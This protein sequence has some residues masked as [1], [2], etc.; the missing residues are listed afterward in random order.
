M[1]LKTFLLSFKPHLSQTSIAEK[2]RSGLAG[3]IAILLLTLAL[4]HLPQTLFPL[5]IVASMAASATLLYATPHSPLAQPW[6]LVGGH[7]VS[8]LAGLA[9]GALIPEPTL[10]AGAAVGSAIL[11]MELLSCLH[12]PSAATSLMMVLGSSQLHEMNW[13]W[14]L[15]IV[16][17]NV[18][19]SLVL[20]LIINNALPGR[21]YPM[22]ALHNPVSPKPA[23]F[24]TLEQSDIAWAL[25]QMNSEIDVSEEDL[26][27]IYKLSLQQAQTRIDRQFPR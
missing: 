1:D 19:I 27:E 8:A 14:A 11:L 26:A 5:L 15:A 13:Q 24:I 20:A 9:C 17:I 18:G 22:H 7:L 10:A 16:T 25:Q 2:L 3:G 12:P 4:H 6:N 21:R 23:P